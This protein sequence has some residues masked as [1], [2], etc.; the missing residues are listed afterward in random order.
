[1]HYKIRSFF[2][3]ALFRFGLDLRRSRSVSFGVDWHRDIRYF[4]NGRELKT[5]LDVGANTGQMALR[6][7]RAFPGSRIY[8]FEPAPST[9]QELSSNTAKYP[10]IEPICCALGADQGSGM[11]TAGLKSEHNKVLVNVEPDGELKP[12]IEVEIDTV[13]CFCSRRG[14]ERVNLL[15]CDTEGYEMNVLRGAQGLLAEGRIDFILAECDF[16]RRESELH[17]EFI[18]IWNYLAGFGFHVVSFYT[19]GVDDLGWVWGDVLLR[20]V[21]TYRPGRI[22]TSPTAR[23]P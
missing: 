16:F 13:D 11:M 4:P 14:I 7:A 5:V 19:G 18:D 20:Q 1:M 9:F 12:L 3:D 21:S 17:S 10:C 2:S 8:S 23:R 15:K 6:V 22:S